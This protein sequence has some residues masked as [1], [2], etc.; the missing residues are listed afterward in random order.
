MNISTDTVLVYTLDTAKVAELVKTVWGF[1]VTASEIDPMAVITAGTDTLGRPCILGVVHPEV[2]SYERE[3]NVVPVMVG[4]FFSVLYGLPVTL[5]TGCFNETAEERKTLGEFLGSRRYY[6][7]RLQSNTYKCDAWL[8]KLHKQ[9]YW[10]RSG[11][12]LIAEPVT[13]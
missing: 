13:A 4:Q 8:K 1:D 9:E 7:E 11:L 2:V 3:Y 6:N 5:L 10:S 12:D